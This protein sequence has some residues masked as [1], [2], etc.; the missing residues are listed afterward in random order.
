M[1]VMMLT[2][3]KQQLHALV[4][5]L[6]DWEGEGV[7]IKHYGI[8]SKT[9]DGFILLEWNCPVPER[10]HYKLKQ[11]EDVID[12]LVYDASSQSIAV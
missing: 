11:D 7:Q 3:F 2:C 10:F 12:Y 4:D 9:K 1:S 8:T 5:E 6:G